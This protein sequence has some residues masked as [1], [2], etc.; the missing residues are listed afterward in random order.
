MESPY[1]TRSYRRCGTARL[2]ASTSLRLPAYDC[3]CGEPH[4]SC[5]MLA[6]EGRGGT[7]GLEGGPSLTPV[8]NTFPL[9][10]GRA[11][12]ANPVCRLCGRE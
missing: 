2:A 12:T 11:G 7:T 8:L 9:G 5:R 10:G 6:Q 1:I 4:S 3:C